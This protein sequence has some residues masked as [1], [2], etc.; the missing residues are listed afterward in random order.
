MVGLTLDSL[1]EH[2][3]DPSRS[4]KLLWTN[5]THSRKGRNKTGNRTRLFGLTLDSLKEH[6]TDLSMSTEVNLDRPDPQQE[7]NKQ[8]RKLYKI[9]WFDSR[10]FIRTCHRSIKVNRS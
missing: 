2:A 7:R 1:K 3:T 5:L 4:T 6:V 10:L 9:G 8:D